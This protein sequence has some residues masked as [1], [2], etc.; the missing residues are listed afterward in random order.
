MRWCRLHFT[1]VA[2]ASLK[3]RLENDT[4]PRFAITRSASTFVLVCFGKHKNH[5]LLQL[6][7]IEYLRR[8]RSMC[9]LTSTRYYLL[10]A[11]KESLPSNRILLPRY[12]F[13]GMLPHSTTHVHSKLLVSLIF[14]D[15]G[16]Y[17]RLRSFG[18]PG[19]ACSM[20]R[21][22]LSDNPFLLWCWFGQQ[23]FG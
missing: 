20:P 4:G 14:P 22:L 17:Q 16:V 3:V 2:P 6:S 18:W 1:A 5:F 7:R 11:T 15:L 12:A 21:L 9:T 10:A 8:M 23:C 13:V 19:D